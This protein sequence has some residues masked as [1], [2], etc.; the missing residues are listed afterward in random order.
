MSHP[1]IKIYNRKTKTIEEERI[2]SERSLRMLYDTP[3]GR[4]VTDKILKQHWFS[5]LYGKNKLRSASARDVSRFIDKYHID[6]TE[7]VET[8]ESF[9]SFNAFFIRKLK[10]ACRPVSQFADTLVAPADSRMTFLPIRNDTVFPVKGKSYR[11]AKLVDDQHIA[12]QYENGICLIFRLAGAD[13]HRF[14]YIDNGKQSAITEHGY[15]LHSIHPVALARNFSPYSDNY[16]NRCILYTENFGH[17][18]Q[19]EVGALTVG[20]IVQHNVNETSITRGTEK[21]YFE[22]GASSIVLLFTR[23]TICVDADIVEISQRGIETKVNLGE[24]IGRRHLT[25]VVG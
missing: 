4:F 2:Y 18:L 6:E 19:L 24:S 14:C 7:F 11:L 23:D 15:G 22:F 5:K 20:R 17:V 13:C 21:G 16:R 10:P 8:T 3:V 9:A 12:H 25:P 1:P